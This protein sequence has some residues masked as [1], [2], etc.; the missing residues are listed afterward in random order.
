MSEKGIFR[1]KELLTPD[2]LACE[3]SVNNNHSFQWFVCCMT[4]LPSKTFPF[5]TSLM[6]KKK[7]K[8]MAVWTTQKKKNDIIKH[9][10]LYWFINFTING[11]IPKELRGINTHWRLSITSNWVYSPQTQSHVHLFTSTKFIE[12]IKMGLTPLISS[13]L[14]CVHCFP[15]GLSNSLNHQSGSPVRSATST[16]AVCMCPTHLK[17]VSQKST[18]PETDVQYCILMMLHD[19]HADPHFTIQCMSWLW[20]SKAILEE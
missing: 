12:R 4:E 18:H 1:Q 5:Q 7:E 9:C 16:A 14:H 3:T 6:N 19:A 17:F 11:R 15:T 2:L 10:L 20:Q 13:L 8:K